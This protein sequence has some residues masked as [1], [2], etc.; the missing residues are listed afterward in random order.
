MSRRAALALVAAILLGL[1]LLDAGLVTAGRT[2]AI[3]HAAL[4][5]LRD[6]LDAAQLRVP[7]WTLGVAIAITTLGNWYVRLPVAALG[8]LLLALR[9]RRREAAIVAASVALAA[10]ALPLLKDLVARSRPDVAVQLVAASHPSFPSGHAFGA[11]VLYPLLGYV[12]GRRALIGC[13]IALAVAIGLSRVF[14]GVHWLSD[15]A[16]GWLLGAAWLFA[17]LALVPARR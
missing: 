17:T 8:A 6:P 4:L 15:V 16:G 11:T 1:F 10:L 7:R 9:G 3:D 2:A 5:W 13:G 14:L 12:A